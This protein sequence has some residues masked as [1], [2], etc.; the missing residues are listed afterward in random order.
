MCRGAS[1][2]SLL[3]FIKLLAQ[4]SSHRLRQ[5][6][7]KMGLRIC[8]ARNAQYVILQRGRGGAIFWPAP[9]CDCGRISNTS[10]N[11]CGRGWPGR[12]FPVGY[13]PCRCPK[14]FG[15]EVGS[16]QH[17]TE[18]FPSGGPRTEAGKIERKCFCCMLRG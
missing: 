16:P 1:T 14:G 10:R 15:A 12:I 9:C 8:S 4:L 2:R 11:A 6:L 18:A 13:W 7:V 17:A 3:F 5:G